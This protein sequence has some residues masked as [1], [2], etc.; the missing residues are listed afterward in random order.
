ME[1]CERLTQRKSYLKSSESMSD[2]KGG[3][4]EYEEK[5]QSFLRSQTKA[6]RALCEN[7]VHAGMSFELMPRQ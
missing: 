7:K 1:N 6:P 3:R 5:D 4:D 2:L